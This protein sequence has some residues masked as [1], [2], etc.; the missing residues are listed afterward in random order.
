MTFPAGELAEISRNG[1]DYPKAVRPQAA[2]SAPVVATSS[3]RS[4]FRL[5]EVAPERLEGL[6]GRDTPCA[7][8]AQVLN[9]TH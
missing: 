6:V 3:A 9:R 7:R 8:A 5:L 2:G 1:A 4:R